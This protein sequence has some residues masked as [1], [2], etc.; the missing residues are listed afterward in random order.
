[1]SMSQPVEWLTKQI[2]PRRTAQILILGHRQYWSILQTGRGL[3]SQAK[4]R[5]WF[6]LSTPIEMAKFFGRSELARAEFTEG[7]SGAQQPTSPTCMWRSPMQV[8][9]PH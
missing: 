8:R 6:T 1:M 5:E 3:W 9:Y 7:S 4:N 2:V